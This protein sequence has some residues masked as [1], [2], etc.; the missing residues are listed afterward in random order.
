MALVDLERMGECILK[1]H[2]KLKKVT[3]EVALEQWEDL[4]L[5]DRVASLTLRHVHKPM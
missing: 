2:R 3:P 5:F 1:V 4:R